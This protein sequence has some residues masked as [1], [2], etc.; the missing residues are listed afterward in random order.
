[1]LIIQT[2]NIVVAQSAPDQCQLLVANYIYGQQ[3]NPKVQSR[4][5]VLPI[6]QNTGVCCQG[7]RLTVKPSIHKRHQAWRRQFQ[8]I[9]PVSR[10]SSERPLKH[11]R[12]LIIP[13]HHRKKASPGAKTDHVI[14]SCPVRRGAPRFHFELRL[15]SLPLPSYDRAFTYRLSAFRGRHVW[16]LWNSNWRS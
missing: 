5:F 4:A 10:S 3:V 6:T 9:A 7:A 2:V 8:P 14:F 1:M 13:Q 16:L 15:T 11:G 12:L